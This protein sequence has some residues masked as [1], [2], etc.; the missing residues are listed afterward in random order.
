MKEKYEKPDVKTE[1]I[2]I[3]SFGDYNGPIPVQQP[4]YGICCT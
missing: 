1:E 2:E 4:N 3:G